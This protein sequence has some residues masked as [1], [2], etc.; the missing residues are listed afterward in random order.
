MRR[1]PHCQ[2]SGGD[3]DG[4]LRVC[5]CCSTCIHRSCLRGSGRGSTCT[6][7]GRP[8][9]R[10]AAWAAAG[11]WRAAL[12][13]SLNKA[14]PGAVLGL[15]P[16][17]AVP[18]PAVPRPQ[19]P[20]PQL[21]RL[22]LPRLLLLPSAPSSPPLLLGLL[23][24][25]LPPPPLSTPPPV[26]VA[27]ASRIGSGGGGGSRS[28]ASTTYS[29]RVAKVARRARREA[30]SY[31]VSA[32]AVQTSHTERVGPGANDSLW[33]ACSRRDPPLRRPCTTRG[34]WQASRTGARIAR[35]NCSGRDG[36][37]FDR[38]SRRPDDRPFELLPPALLPWIGPPT[39]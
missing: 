18:R 34:F 2:G 37:A 27:T 12:R 3:H 7:G 26:A 15:G 5:A 13:E 22:L 31:T 25:L 38:A 9:S 20:R 14:K 29:W 32:F 19:L 33:R 30:P 28:L 1:R 24:L 36:A 23:L 17:P 35:Q 16:R 6:R 4:G 21:P 8:R 11:R 39:L 10:G